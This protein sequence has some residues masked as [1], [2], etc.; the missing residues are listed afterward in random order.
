MSSDGD[1]AGGAQCKSSGGKR[2]DGVRV[3]SDV[4]V[5]F[6]WR[7]DGSENVRVLA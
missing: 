2:D 6:E 5:A 3:D 1:V 7:L 4:W